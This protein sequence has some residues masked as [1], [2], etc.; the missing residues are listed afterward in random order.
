V[1]FLPLSTQS[2]HQLLDVPE[3]VEPTLEDLHAI[4]DIPGDRSQPLCLHRPSFRDLLL[5]RK[6]CGNDRFYVDEKSTHEKLARCCLELMSAPSGL[7][8]DMYNHSDPRVLR[9]EIDKGTIDRNLPP[10]LQYACRYWVGQLER[11]EH[12]IEDGDATHLFLEKHLPHWLEAMSL[13]SETSSYRA[14]H[15]IPIYCSFLAILFEGTLTQMPQ[16]Q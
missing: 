14:T 6:K 12:S 9:R 11:S 10:E 1:L 3:G 2:L 7:Q 13:V 8:Q 16:S 15:I 4:L 5:N